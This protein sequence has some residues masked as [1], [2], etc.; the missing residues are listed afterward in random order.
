MIG[1]G[2]S[3]TRL[4]A[5]SPSASA[6]VPINPLDLTTPPEWYEGTTGVGVDE[7][8][9]TWLDQGPNGL[10]LT[11]A[12][13]AKQPAYNGTDTLT[14]DGVDDFLMNT[15]MPLSGSDLHVFVVVSIDPTGVDNGRIITN[16]DGPDFPSA[17]VPRM[18][19]VKSSGQVA[20]QD[21]TLDKAITDGDEADNTVKLLRSSISGGVASMAV[22]GVVQSATSSIG[23]ALIS[24]KL[25]V[26]LGNITRAFK[27]G[28]K[29]IV[30]VR[31]FMSAEEIIGTTAYLTAKHEM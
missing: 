13:A 26:G 22:G 18:M 23:T 19:V 4:A 29:E 28:I 11:Q 7:G 12:V 21:H 1:G 31:G 5:C 30:N 9:L 27:G 17:G 2:V 14:F 16:N 10:H 8:T 25:V 24:T 15:S 20:L 3:I 6:P